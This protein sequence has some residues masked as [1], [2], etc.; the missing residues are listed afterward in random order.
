MLDPLLGLKMQGAILQGSS[1]SASSGRPFY[2]DTKSARTDE[3][4]G[5][6]G[7]RQAELRTGLC[8]FTSNAHE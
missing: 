3:G 2:S 1:W 8:V 6:R 4:M 5:E 7:Q